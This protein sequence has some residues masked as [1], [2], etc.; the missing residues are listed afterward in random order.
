LGPLVVWELK[1][2]SREETDASE[3]YRQLRNYMHQIPT[4]FVYNAFCVMSDQAITKAGTITASE[5]CFI[6]W[7]TTDGSYENTQ[8]ARF[9][10]FIEGIFCK[11]RLLDILKNFICFSGNQKIL[12]AYHQY[13]AV[14]RAIHSDAK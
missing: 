13:F 12:A 10:T 2:P 1:S 5:D 11:E 9:D 3:A 4:L 14:R 8:F 7:K 6:E